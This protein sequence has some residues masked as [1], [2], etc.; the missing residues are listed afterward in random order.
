[1]E[2]FPA[3]S[4]A[5]ANHVSYMEK[6]RVYEMFNNMVKMLVIHQP[7][8]HMKFLLWYLKNKLHVDLPKII[9]IAPP[10][11]T[12]KVYIALN[13]AKST[14]A[15]T[16]DRQNVLHRHWRKK[17]TCPEDFP[18][19]L[20][21]YMK[22]KGTWKKGWILLD[23]PKNKDEANKLIGMG[24]IPTHTIVLEDHHGFTNWSK[25]DAFDKQYKQMEFELKTVFSN[26]LKLIDIFGKSFETVLDLCLEQV[27]Y[28]KPLAAPFIPRIVLIGPIGSRRFSIAKSLSEKLKI[29]HID[30]NQISSQKILGH[31]K[32]DSV[33][34]RDSIPIETIYGWIKSKITTNKACLTR[35]YVLTGFPRSRNDLEWLDS[36]EF[37]PNRITF[38]ELYFWG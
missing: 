6:H 8:D 5:N 22:A 15:I 16:I 2:L 37:P 20:V 12:N 33:F 29:V 35:G 3:I 23:I 4:L 24:I 31:S 32:M 27:L 1:M 11:Y 13:I 10:Q 28:Q 34:S 17:G 30:A 9:F 14:G 36:I 7:A 19:M 38:S 21:D 26:S 25:Y 18:T